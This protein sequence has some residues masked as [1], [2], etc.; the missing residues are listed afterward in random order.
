MIVLNMQRVECNHARTR[1]RAR[2]AEQTHLRS[3][4]ALSADRILHEVRTRILGAWYVKLGLRA[5]PRTLQPRPAQTRARNLNSKK[6][7]RGSVDFMAF[8]QGGALRGPD[9]RFLPGQAGAWRQ[10][11]EQNVGDMRALADILRVRHRFGSRKRRSATPTL[12][13]APER[14]RE[15]YVRWKLR[16]Q[17]RMAGLP[18]DRVS[19]EGRAAMLA[20]KRKA[21]QMI[22]DPTNREELKARVFL[23]RVRTNAQVERAAN[24]APLRTWWQ[25]QKRGDQLPR[26]ALS[27]AHLSSELVPQPDDPAKTWRR[28]FD[29]DPDIWAHLEK[30]LPVM[31]ARGSSS[32]SMMD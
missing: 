2:G 11:Q 1:R 14:A 19:T 15:V 27:L 30:S 18:C 8:M 3:V 13:S 17:H 16:K 12:E 31:I 6:K 25:Q 22:Q 23:L 24:D 29:W 26:G 5:T 28:T 32:L 7:A 4:A 21:A 10:A 9:G 20:I